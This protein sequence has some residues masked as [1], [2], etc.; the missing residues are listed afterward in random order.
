MIPLN[1][2]CLAAYSREKPPGTE[3]KILDA[4]IKGLTHEDTVEE[5]ATF[6]PCLIGITTNTCVFDSVIALINLLKVS[7]SDVPVVI[8]GPHPS[9]IPDSSLCDS[10]ADFAVIGEGE[11]TIADL[12]DA[13]GN[14]RTLDNIDGIAYWNGDSVIVNKHREL[15]KDIDIL[16][17]P[18]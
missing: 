8:G 6:N 11:R 14:K 16:P 4:E 9:A 10:K 1:L 17:F 3:F 13:V 5:A 12:V 18:A 15:I 2:C 7:L